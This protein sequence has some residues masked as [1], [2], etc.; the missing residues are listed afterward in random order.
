MDK[1]PPHQDAM[2]FEG[3]LSSN[4][5]VVRCISVILVRKGFFIKHTILLNRSLVDDT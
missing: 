1:A 4:Q 5:D 3:L 2:L